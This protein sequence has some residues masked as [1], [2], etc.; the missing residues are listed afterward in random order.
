MN[1]L[2][3]IFEEQLTPVQ[4]VKVIEEW[5]LILRDEMKAKSP[6]VESIRNV[7]GKC[8]L[9]FNKHPRYKDAVAVYSC[10]I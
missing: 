7:A 1:S 10:E 2:E 3:D 4:R 5:L 9:G 8:I 6:A